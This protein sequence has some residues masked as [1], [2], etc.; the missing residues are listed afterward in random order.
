MPHT[1]TDEYLTLT[2]I[3]VTLRVPLATVRGWRLAGTGPKGIRV[4][5][6]IRVRRADFEAWLKTRED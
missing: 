2:E 4:G 6:H 3:A 5:K 1:V